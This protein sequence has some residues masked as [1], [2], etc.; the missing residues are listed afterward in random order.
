[1]NQIVVTGSCLCEKVRYSITS[2]FQ[3]F[4]F[5]HCKQCRKVT[6][7]AF[8]A[9]IQAKPAEITWISGAQYVKRFDYL[10]ERL[11]TKVFCVE[12]GS[13]LPFLNK[14]GTKLFIPAGSLDSKPCILPGH[15]I[16]WDDRSSWYEAGLS[17][18]RYEGFAE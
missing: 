1:M 11:F 15:N 18:P 2:E 4:Y 9:N 8:A 17:A 10:G 5:C 12:C 14:S 13:G 16:F 6:G 7:S 3:Q